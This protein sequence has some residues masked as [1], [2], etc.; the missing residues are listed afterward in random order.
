MLALT[1]ALL[2]AAPVGSPADGLLLPRLSLDLAATAT[3]SL[4]SRLQ[5]T[6]LASDDAPHRAPVAR[7]RS[8]F[9]ESAGFLAGDALALGVFAAG[10]ALT[11]SVEGEDALGPA[12]LTVM[13]TSVAALL[14]PPMLGVLA[15]GRTPPPRGS[16]RALLAGGAL[17][18]AGLV[19]AASLVRHDQRWLAA[20]L[21]V[22]IDLGVAPWVVVRTLRAA[23]DASDS[24]ERV[25]HPVGAASPGA[26]GR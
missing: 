19:A 22:A 4:D 9:A 26:I 21:V 8:V 11:E 17:H 18:V 20:G 15:A 2:A 10:S 6:A 24:D 12:V 14:A 3:P 13:Y 25:A 16:A 23:S 5:Q 7:P 1:L